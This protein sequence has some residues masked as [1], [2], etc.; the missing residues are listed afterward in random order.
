MEMWVTNWETE[1]LSPGDHMVV[2]C[3]FVYHDAKKRVFPGLSTHTLL[4]FY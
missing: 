1:D 2:I 3:I 4:H